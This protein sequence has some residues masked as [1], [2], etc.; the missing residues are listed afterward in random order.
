MHVVKDSSMKQQEEGEI[1]MQD[2]EGQVKPAGKQWFIRWLIYLAGMVVL[3]FGITLNTKTG[4]GVSPIISIAYSVSQIWELNFGNTTLALYCLLVV[5]QFV[6][7]RKNRRWTDLL[8]VPV[9]LLV[10][11]LLNLFDYLLDIQLASFWWNLLLLIAAILLT[12]LGVVLSVNMRLVPNPGDG[13]VQ[14]ISD[15]TGKGLGL[16]KNLFDVGCILCSVAIGLIFAGK[17]VGIGLGT[18]LAVLGVGR[19][20][21]LFNRLLKE[22]MLRAAGLEKK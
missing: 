1:N 20:V 19:A 15:E 3:A 10:S 11:Q 13:I 22:N 9:A 7:R 21:A 5:A 17:L 8:Q 14:A 18:I 16:T 2:S 6:I 12:G 4:L